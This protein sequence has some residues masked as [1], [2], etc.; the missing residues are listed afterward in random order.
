[1]FD[2]KNES[3]IEH[4]A[5]T[6]LK[7][8]RP[9]VEAFE[10]ESLVAKCG[11]TVT[12][13]DVYAL[14]RQ[15][16][17]FEAYR[18]FV[19]SN[20]TVAELGQIP[21]VALDVITA[22]F[23]T[24]I[25]PLIA[26]TQPIEE[27][28]G[29]IYFKQIRATKTG[30]GRTAGE[31]ISDARNGD[32][33]ST[34]YGS[35]EVSGDEVTPVGGTLAGTLTYTVNLPKFPIRPGT[36]RLDT[37]ITGVKGMDDSKG[38]ILGKGIQGD[39]N[40]D[41]GVL[42][43]VFSADP[44]AGK[45]VRGF[46]SVNVEA[47]DEVVGIAGVLESDV[48][49]AEVMALTADTGLLQEYSFNKRFG[50]LAQDE[51]AQDLTSELGRVMNSNAIRRLDQACTKEVAWSKT[52]PAAVSITEHKLSFIDAFASAENL[53]NVSAGRGSISR[54]IAGTNAAALLRGMPGFT[55]ADAGLSYSVGLYGY[56]NGIPVIRASTL[57]ASDTILCCYKGNGYFDAPLVNAPY[58][59][60]FVS[61]TV[62][63]GANPLRGRRV[64]A[65]WSGMKVVVPN[66]IVRIRIT[67]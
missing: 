51:V 18:E 60:L 13:S 25:L 48:I 40:Y 34:S 4:Y 59:P 33:Y 23:G 45:I 21:T 22:G 57:I 58:M 27:E 49:R 37:D 11:Q 9:Q 36:V 38:N 19:E 50:R 5:E 1:M 24:S 8:Y 28:S 30:Y 31:V 26:S 62:S 2:V 32:S 63:A 14:G 17:Q 46:Y 44:G 7:K 56:L 55:P 29:V 3:A 52:P 43:F 64:A 6:Y 53:L 41:T 66:F 16:E 42:T 35:Y 47:A 54:M 15:L 67:A 20:G 65:V 39:I 10:S 61:S 12:A